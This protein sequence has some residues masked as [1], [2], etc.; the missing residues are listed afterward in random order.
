MAGQVN[1]TDA[2]V[3]DRDENEMSYKKRETAAKQEDL[4]IVVKSSNENIYG[5]IKPSLSRMISMSD[6]IEETYKKIEKG[7]IEHTC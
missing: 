4:D 3:V 5:E 2:A 1:E 6:Q 7:M